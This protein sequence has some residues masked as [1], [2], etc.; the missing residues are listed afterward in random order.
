MYFSVDEIS[1]YWK[2]M[3]CRIFIERSQYLA[4]KDRLTLVRG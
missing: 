2:K 3:L 4:S 1:L